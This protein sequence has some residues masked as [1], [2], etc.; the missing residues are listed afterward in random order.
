MAVKKSV[1]YK[2]GQAF[3]DWLQERA[4]FVKVLYCWMI[5]ALSQ[6]KGE[7]ERK[8]E[9]ERERECVFVREMGKCVYEWLC[10][11]RFWM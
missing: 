8:R 3:F 11:V 6:K 10:N 2:N 5:V 1:S 9:R 4:L 7:R